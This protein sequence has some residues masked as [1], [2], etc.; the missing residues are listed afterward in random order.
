[1]DSFTFL[2]VENVRTSQE[3]QA[4]TVCYKDSFTFLYVE[5]VRTSHETQTSTAGYKDNFTFSFYQ[6]EVDSQLCIPVVLLPSPPLKCRRYPLR[7]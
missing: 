7:L 4:S 3:T 1:M 2:Y 5:D 6:V